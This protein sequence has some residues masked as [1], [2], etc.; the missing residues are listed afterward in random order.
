MRTSAAFTLEI[1]VFHGGLVFAILQKQTQMSVETPECKALICTS[2]SLHWRAR[3]AAGKFLCA[4][5]QL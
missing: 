5:L 2:G 3:V 4:R 1:F